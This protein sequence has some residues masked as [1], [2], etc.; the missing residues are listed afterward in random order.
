MQGRRKVFR[1][2]AING[3]AQAGAAGGVHAGHHE[4]MAEL[5]ALRAIVEPQEAVQQ[6]LDAYKAQAAEAH[7]LKAELDIISAAIAKTKTEIATLHVA[8]F[9]GPQMT[10]VT[11][12]LDA[13]IDG[14]EQATQQILTAA[15]LIDQQANTLSASVRNEQDRMLAADIQE[16]VIQVF[17]ACNF[18]DVTGQR[19]GKVVATLKFIET[20]IARMVEIW[21]GLEALADLT[22][23]AM[24]ARAGARGLLDG[25]RLAG[26]AGHADQDQI[27]ALFA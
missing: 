13:V 6:M 19:I 26:E 2:E 7:K 12:E 24:A 17:E 1:I 14:T 25:P 4:I 22:P 16:Q 15:E 9:E 20:H 18:Q 8:G 23:E 3:A 27:D 5:K 10:R 11:D 21:G